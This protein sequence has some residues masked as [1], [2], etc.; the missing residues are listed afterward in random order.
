MKAQGVT[1]QPQQPRR[2]TIDQVLGEEADNRF[3]SRRIPIVPV[4]DLSPCCG[5]ICFMFSC[6]P[7]FPQC[8]GA[9]VK[10]RYCC[11]TGESMCCKTTNEPGYNCICSR[12]EIMTG[13]CV[14][15][16]QHES[17]CCCFDYR[18]S[19]PET[20]GYPCICA[21]C[22]YTCCYKW[23]NIYE[24]CGNI[25]SYLR[26][27]ERPV[28]E[29]QAM[30]Q[31]M[32]VH[33]RPSM[34]RINSEASGTSLELSPQEYDDYCKARNINNEDGTISTGHVVAELVED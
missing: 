15:F 34:E 18:V 5:C 9:Y 31:I 11:C 13:D 6:Y 28:V 24:C 20:A 10:S 7:K 8:I 14:A 16:C 22:C 21:F 12:S 33:S 4:R 32:H 27:L 17:Q 26:L 3:V 1:N 30:Q 29:Q 19:C 25:E 2:E 23:N